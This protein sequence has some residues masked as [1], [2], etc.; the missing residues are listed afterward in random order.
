M[1]VSI[2]S[3]IQEFTAVVLEKD[4]LEFRELSELSFDYNISFV[5][6][7]IQ[8]TDSQVATT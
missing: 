5:S 4:E 3:L 1:K 2:Q 7:F 6:K 8:K